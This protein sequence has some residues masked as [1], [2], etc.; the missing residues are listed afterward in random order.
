[1]SEPR[2]GY[3]MC[4][5]C[6][7]AAKCT[8]QENFP[9]WGIDLDFVSTGYYGGFID[10]APPSDSDKDLRWKMCH[11]CVVKFLE[12]FP[13]LAAKTTKGYHPCS[14]EQPCCRW[15]WRINEATGKSEWANEDKVWV[16][17][18]D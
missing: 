1:M 5:A 8:Q 9:D 14:D 10:N 3:E 6:G 17:Y 11:D 18:E 15:A 7:V 12:T 13:M 16:L 4:D 2:H